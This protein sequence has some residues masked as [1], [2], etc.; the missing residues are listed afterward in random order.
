[1]TSIS[2][3]V[4]KY[5]YGIKGASVV[6]HKPKTNLQHQVF[7]FNDWPGGIYGT[8]AFQGTKPAAP[9][10]A[11]WAVMHFLGWE[12]Y[13]RLAEETMETTKRLIAGVRDIDGVHVW[14]KPDMTVVALGSDKVDILAAGDLLNERGWHFDRQ[15]GPP[16]LHLMASPRHKLVVDEFLADLRY[17]VEHAP[18][19]SAKA[20]SYGDD[21]SAEAAGTA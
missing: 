4:H 20:A 16:A 8:Q 13:L 18:A 5:G 11:A 6:L 9:I 3:D 17:A 10:A 15:E 7:F 2:A 21:V 1:V 19:S 14:G 12:G